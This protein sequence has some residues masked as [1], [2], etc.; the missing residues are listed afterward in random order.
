[1]DRCP[2]RFVLVESPAQIEKTAAI[3]SEIWHECYAELLGVAQIDYMVDKFQS[4]PALTAA[5]AED[6]YEYYLVCLPACQE[7]EDAG[8]AIGYIGLQS[9]D[10]MLLLSKLYLLAAHRHR[11]YTSEVLRFVE[12]RGRA[13]A[14]R[15]VW[16][17]VNR[18][19]TQAIAVYNKAGFANTRQQV[20]DIGGG[21]VMDDYIFEKPL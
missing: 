13:L 19:N 9:K 4:V 1:M 8:E 18:Q 7:G 21:Y 17:T 20:A 11:G 5:I 15:S 2:L 10:G 12:A 3:A 6:G 16:L 14:C